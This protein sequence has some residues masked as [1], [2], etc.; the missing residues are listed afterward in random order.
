MKRLVI[1][2]MIILLV[3]AGCAAQHHARLL[4]LQLRGYAAAV[5]WS[6][7]H[8]ALAY[9]DPA[10]RP[11][12]EQ[13]ALV[14]ARLEQ[15]QVVSYEVLAGELDPEARQ[16]VQTARLELANRH[17]G[18]TRV[19]QDRQRWRFDEEAGRWWLVTGLPDITRR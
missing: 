3:L 12:A 11:S 9:V 1:S 2:P 18:A 5:R 4:D 16:Y 7:F 8:S 15:V 10:E 19:V 13:Q 14:L 6:D 17:T